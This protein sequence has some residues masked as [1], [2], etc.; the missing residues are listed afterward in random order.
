MLKCAPA[1]C[2]LKKQVP[3]FCQANAFCHYKYRYNQQ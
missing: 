2:Q 3:G 1:D